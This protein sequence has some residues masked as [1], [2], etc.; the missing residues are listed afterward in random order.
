MEPPTKQR[1][2]QKKITA[3]IQKNSIAKQMMINRVRKSRTG[4]LKMFQQQ[5][6][7]PT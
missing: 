6:P 2:S 7:G 3:K 5:Q 4:M 1:K